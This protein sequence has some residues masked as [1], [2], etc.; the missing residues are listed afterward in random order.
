VNENSPTLIVL[1]VAL[2]LILLGSLG[3]AGARIYRALPAHS[4]ETS[5]TGAEQDLTIVVRTQSSGTTRIKLYPI[6]FDSIEREYARNPRPGKTFEDFLALRLQN[7]TPV[8]TEA[9][10]NGRAIARVNE[11]NWW[12]HAVS[13][14][15]SGEWLE[16]RRS[17]NVAQRPQTIEL[18][19]DNAYERSKKF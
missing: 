7:L 11:G 14:F 18:S 3:W 9:D 10:R 4:G 12:L 8:T 1:Q 15:P 17:L 5:R 19:S 2:A 16:W 13:A 6:D